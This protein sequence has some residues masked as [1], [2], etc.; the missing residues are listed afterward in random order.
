MPTTRNRG[1]ERHALI[2]FLRRGVSAAAL[3]APILAAPMWGPGGAAA[4]DETVLSPISVTAHE[5][6]PGGF[7]IG[8]EDL[9]H[10]NPSDIKEV[11]QGEAGV[12]VGGGADL[13]RKTYVNGLEDSNLNVKIDG[14]RQVGTT[15]HHL[16]TTVIDPNLL[17]SV[18]VETGVAPADVGP[19][20]LGGSIAYETKDARDIIE[21]GEMQKVSLKYQHDTNTNAHSPTVTYAAQ[22]GGFEGMFHGSYD[23]GNTYED[24]RGNEVIGTAPKIKN[25]LAK[26]AWTSRAGHRVEVNGSYLQDEAIRPNRVNFTEIS[27][28]SVPVPQSYQRRSLGVTY[29]D[30]APSEWINPE[31]VLSFNEI[32]YSVENLALAGNHDLKSKTTSYSGKLANSFATGLGVASS[33]SV[34]AG[35]DFYRD[36]GQNVFGTHPFGSGR[37]GIYTERSLN[38]GAFVQSRLNWTEKLRTSVGAR[39]DRQDLHGI[40][41]TKLDF[42][43]ASGN[44]NAE[45]DVIKGLTGYVGGGT[46]FGGVPLG[47]SLIY[48]FTSTWNY[49]DVDPSRS[50]SGKVGFKGE[51]GG[52]S[53]DAHIFYTRVLNAH[54]RGDNDRR[55]NNNL[56]TKGFNLS[57]KYDYGDGFVRAT[58]SYQNLRANGEVLLTTSSSYHGFNMGSTMT[59]DAAH[60]FPSWGLRIGA[61][62][63]MAF[64]QD[65][66]PTFY[67]NFYLTT[68]IYA[69]WQPEKISNMDVE[70]LTLRFDIKN[71]FDRTYVDRATS[72]T[73]SNS[74]SAYHEPGRTFLLTAKMDF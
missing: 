5:V 7:Q 59:V 68:N 66:D 8:E 48:N 54:Q 34:T 38:V 33:G 2:T 25:F 17:K 24:G 16:G 11:F 60:T 70:G 14:A 18:R 13:A 1:A 64:H 45:Y 51:H 3:S 62:N 72:G 73:D 27:N 46:S 44:A 41:G 36:E 4:A 47:E 32:R 74:T 39:F 49:V 12:N 43:G 57:G 29:K 35:I 37:Q 6:S 69:Q 40:D 55:S 26:G 65:D 67:K 58:Y 63:E 61:S 10:A 9:E 31:V 71:L 30:E 56:T 22:V 52:F 15:F 53:G 19:A 23:N 20:T 50:F 21:P 28:G 42:Q